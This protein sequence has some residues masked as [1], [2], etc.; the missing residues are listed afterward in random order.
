MEREESEGQNTVVNWENVSSLLGSRRFWAAL[1]G[2]CVVLAQDYDGLSEDAAQQIIGLI[3]A[4]VVG[5]AIRK[6]EKKK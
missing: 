5:D 1:I 4:W 2:V 3:M 6:T